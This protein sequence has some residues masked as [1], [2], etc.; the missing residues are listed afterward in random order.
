MKRG[1]YA[2]A[3]V[4]VP[5]RGLYDEI[6]GRVRPDWRGN[7]NYGIVSQKNGYDNFMGT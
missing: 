2:G 3:G 1:D 5:A 6:L 7:I 4:R